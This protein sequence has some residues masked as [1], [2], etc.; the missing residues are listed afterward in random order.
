MAACNERERRFVVALVETGSD[1]TRAALYA[2]Y[3]DTVDKD[4]YNNTA[5]VAG[6]R[7]AHRPR[8]QAAIREEA[9]RRINGTAIL[10]ASVLVEIMRDPL[11]K[12]RYKAAVESLNRAGLQVTT[13]HEV[14]VRDD[15]TIGQLEEF[16]R[17]TAA[18]HGLDPEQLMGKSKP[19]AL[20]AP[21]DAEWEDVEDESDDGLEDLFA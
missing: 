12:D 10:A 16:I 8:V 3:R 17:V 5:A 1:N 13:K 15:R 4:G 9:E 2:G 7:L 11:H 19:L 14:N 6:Y 20:E 21:I 18:K